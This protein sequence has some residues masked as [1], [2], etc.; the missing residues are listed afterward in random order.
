MRAVGVEKRE[1]FDEL[2]VVP[3]HHVGFKGQPGFA[4][5]VAPTMGKLLREVQRGGMV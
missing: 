5:A 1:A 2:R 3:R 4:E